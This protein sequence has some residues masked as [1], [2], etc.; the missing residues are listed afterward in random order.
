MTSL[1]I[2]VLAAGAALAL[3]GPAAAAPA[4]LPAIV[5]GVASDSAAPAGAAACSASSSGAPGVVTTTY[6]A[7][8]SGY[9]NARLTGGGGDWDLLVRDA[10]SGERLGGSQGFGG[11]E[12]VQTWIGAG[13]K[14]VAQACRRAGAARDA[15]VAFSLVDVAP[16]AAPAG[17]PS[18]V[19]VRGTAAKLARVDRLNGLDVTESRGRDWADVVVAGSSALSLLR[20]TGLPF[21]TRVADL[22]ASYDSARAADRA[23]AAAVGASPLPSGRTTYRTPEDIQ[24]ELKALVEA[25]PDLV[26]PVVIGQ[27]FQG[28]D[29]SGVE[30]AHDVQGHDGRPTYFLM[31][32]HHARE[33]PSAEAAMEYA[34]MLVKDASS[35]R[36]A[37]LLRRERTLVVPVVN[38]DGYVSTRGAL[39]LADTTGDP[40]DVLSLVESVAPLGGS[41]AYRRKNCDGEI[42]PSATP[43]ELTWGVDNNRNYGNLWGGP[44]SSSDVTS[45]SYHGPGPRSEP[46][47]RAVWDYVR[48]H[49]VTFL[50]TLHTVAALVLRPPGLSGAG[51]APDEARMKAIGD[52]MGA[53][54]G[55][56]SQYSW[57]LYDTAGTTEDDTY[58]ATGGYGY[59]IEMGPPGGNFH[60]AYETG[61]VA[62][63]TGENDHAQGHGGLREALLIAGEAAANPADHAVLHGTAPAGRV[64]RVRRAFDTV[65]SPW[66][67]KG[68]EPVVD[69]GASLCLTGAQDPLTLHDTLDATTVVPASGRYEWHVD[70]STRPFVGG[71]AVKETLTDVDPPVATFSGAPGAPTGTVDHAF[72]LA[73]GETADK[74][75]VTLDATLPEDYDIEVLRKGADGALTSVGTSANAPGTAEQVVLDHPAAGDYVVRVSYYAAVTG[76]YTV[77]VVRAV[78]TRETTPGH[79]EA[80]ALTCETPDGTVLESRD[81]VV[82]RGQSLALDLACGAPAAAPPG[83]ASSS[84]AAPSA[85]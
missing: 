71:G 84:T 52:A 49:E 16:P 41:F 32:A 74:L 38:V 7:P 15:R 9:L 27:T 34:T 58:A 25:H 31:G 70:P 1:R 77:N 73:A 44:G 83:A 76:S 48:T 12:L 68:I 61:V 37:S 82:D 80:Y 63:W 20:A 22:Q 79:Q 59:T 23:Y 8:M 53:A 47:T 60:E 54:A 51:L 39:D 45:Q 55:Y 14:V 21:T 75:R 65:T 43:C 17:H 35:P 28:R 2:L 62:E 3:A 29:I 42:G 4:V 69:I 24:A 10:S 33:W 57:Q 46:E 19:R 50:M 67:A 5:A 72:T 64:L 40:G 30:I 66:C 18:L 78:A 26:R 13:Q 6:R 36:I 11:D 85:P 56:T 81:V